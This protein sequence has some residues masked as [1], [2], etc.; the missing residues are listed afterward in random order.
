MDA[1]SYR[2][3]C[4]IVLGSGLEAE[5]LL[6][7]RRLGAGGRAVHIL[8]EGPSDARVEIS[9]NRMLEG[10]FFWHPPTWGPVTDFGRRFGP[11][12]HRYWSHTG[13]MAVALRRD[14]KAQIYVS[15][16]D[17]EKMSHLR[18]LDSEG[19][20]EAELSGEIVVNPEM[21]VARELEVGVVNPE[22]KPAGTFSWRFMLLTGLFLL[23]WHS[24]KWL[25]SASCELSAVE[26]LPWWR[27]LLAVAYL[28]PALPGVVQSFTM[29][30]AGEMPSLF[31]HAVSSLALVTMSL[32]GLLQLADLPNV[33][34]A[35]VTVFVMGPMLQ[36]YRGR[37][38]HAQRRF[39]SCLRWG[40]AQLLGTLGTAVVMTG[41]VLVYTFLISQGQLLIAS[42]CLPVATSLT[43]MGMVLFTARVY[44]RLVFT[45]RPEVS[46]DLS[47]I[48]MPG[49]IM[50]AHAFAESVR[51]VSLWAGAAR[52]GSFSWVGAALWS[53][54]LNVLNRLGWIR[55]GA[56]RIM[57]PMLGTEL[58]LGLFA[59]TSWSKLHDELKIYGGYFRFIVPLALIAAR[60]LLFQDLRVTG[61]RAPAFNLSGACAIPALLLL[62]LLEDRVVL[63]E[64]LPMGPIPAEVLETKVQPYNSDPGA[65]ISV[66]IRPSRPRT[67]PTAQDA[68]RMKELNAKGTRRISTIQSVVPE[69]PPALVDHLRSL[70]TR[71]FTIRSQ[72]R[73]RLGQERE[74]IPALLLQGL[75]EMPFKAHLTMGMVM[76]FFTSEWLEAALGPGFMKGLCET[77]NLKPLA[78][79]W[80]PVPLEC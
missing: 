6:L 13:L 22:L 25:A 5:E 26:G 64:L 14:Q 61:P 52:S 72:L 31:T 66:E 1:Q 58:S 77:S 44:T 20:V 56:F 3:H 70:G 75:R 11:S 63:H 53:L 71:R 47:Y 57:K 36:Y 24:V 49:M 45:K 29:S 76:C 62:E 17:S 51:L 27:G 59:P 42:M 65:L 34:I 46:G 16:E 23:P 41:I 38:Q 37:A 48:P 18:I 21:E 74:V 68:W 2:D 35:A 30:L 73:R 43:E 79:L 7:R 55:Y 69:Q 32:I 12:E 8:T 19:S 40:L 67:T 39:W 60:A 15:S 78:L 33:M 80:Q 54:L 9:R 10:C 50:G 4:L 28:F